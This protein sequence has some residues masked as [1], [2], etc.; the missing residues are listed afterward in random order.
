[1]RQG[2]P[3]KEFVTGGPKNYTYKLQN[4]KTECKIRGFKLDE[5]E[6]ALLNFESIKHHILAEIYDPEE[7]RRTIAVPLTST[8]NETVP[9][10]KSVLS[11][12]NNLSKQRIV[13]ADPM[14]T[15][16]CETAI[17][18]RCSFLGDIE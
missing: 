2:I 18:Y 7:E 14:P 3:I 12:I 9:P 10:R 1:M 6:S 15:S 5:P 8:L 13:Q 17:Y 16:G 11:L 4:G